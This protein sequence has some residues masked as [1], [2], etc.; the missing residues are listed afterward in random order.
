MSFSHLW[1]SVNDESLCP[2]CDEPL[3]RY[4]S[5]RLQT[6]LDRAISY[7]RPQPRSSNSEGLTAPFATFTTVCNQHRNETTVIPEGVAQG[8]PMHIEFDALPARLRSLRS[9]LQL[10]IEN[11]KKSTFFQDVL[12]DVASM[13]ALAAVGAQGQLVAFQR[14]RPG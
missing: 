1:L 14:T 5:E 12:K 6:L 4:P 10:L 7:A 3:P 9:R 13:G 11:P 8:W 2:F